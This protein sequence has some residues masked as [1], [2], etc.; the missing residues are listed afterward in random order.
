MS[1]IEVVGLLLGVIPLVISAMEHYKEGIDIITDIRNYRSTLKSLKTKLSI[2][3]ELYR[4]TLQ[5]LLLSELSP[6]EVHALFPEPGVK[7]SSASWGTKDIEDK[8]RRK[9][10]VKYDIFMAVVAD[11]N[12][13]MEELME[14]L[15][16][17][18]NGKPKWKPKDSTEGRLQDRFAWEWRRIRRSFGK[19]EREEL[20][21][22]FER[23]NNNLAS[24]VQNSEILAPQSDGR[25]KGFVKYL[26]LVRSQACGLHS[27]LGNSWRCSCNVPH[28]A[29]LRLQHPSE[30][31]PSPPKFGVTFPSRQ[32]S[33][34]EP[35]APA[36]REAVLW[37]HTSVSISKLDDQPKPAATVTDLGTPPLSNAASQASHVTVKFSSSLKVT[38]EK[39]SSRVQFL[40][41]TKTSMSAPTIVSLDPPKVSAPLQSDVSTSVSLCWALCMATP[42]E[43]NLGHFLNASADEIALIT[44]DATQESSKPFCL[45][46]LLSK[47]ANPF[48][49]KLS[50]KDRLKI[51]LTLASTVLQL[52]D[53]PWMDNVWSAQDIQFLSSKSAD[54]FD[55]P[56]NGPF[57]S[58]SFRKPTSLAKPQ[59]LASSGS[60]LADSL[61]P[62]KILFA[63]AV[64][65]VELCLD[66]TLVEMRQPSSGE[67]TVAKKATLLDDY[68]TAHD[69]LNAVYQKSGSNYGDVVQRCLKCAFDIT[70]KQKR[71]DFEKFRY[72]V[73][74]GV[75]A[76]LEDNYKKYLLYRGDI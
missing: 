76:P 4:G 66:K 57:V 49:P 56:I 1:G 34:A 2:Q 14:K 68:E 41:T 12:R 58:T 73:Y 59:Q 65:L 74:E 50:D 70:P 43:K 48:Y 61:I 29:Y 40:T 62:S 5:R 22:S 15:D 20:I 72:L 67:E 51:A 64:M 42:A 45:D 10:G 9:L 8:L 55:A 71:L 6:L 19:A 31:S 7:G 17:D 53:S 37:K 30:A 26:D 69:Q 46:M 44:T 32:T 63:L 38:R 39:K 60:S 47:S 16:I 25:G 28:K 35:E 54:S 27:I 36:E 24:F 75:V 21:S 18:M 23:Y 13:I 11:M 52:Y 3:E 33:T